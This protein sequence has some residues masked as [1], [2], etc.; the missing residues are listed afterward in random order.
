MALNTTT[1]QQILEDG[2]ATIESQATAQR[3]ATKIVAETITAAIQQ[4][5]AD[6]EVRATAQIDNQ[7][8][9]ITGTIQ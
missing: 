6:A 5:L 2:F 4:A 3:P 7:T 9:N 8:I 1:I